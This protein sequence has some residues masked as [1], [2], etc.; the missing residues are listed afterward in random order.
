VTCPRCHQRRRYGDWPAADAIG[1]VTVSF[2][3]WPA[4][5]APTFVACLRARFSSRLTVIDER[6]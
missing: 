5:L 3:N 2:V 1:N 4:D 6:F